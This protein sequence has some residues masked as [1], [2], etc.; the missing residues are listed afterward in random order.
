CA[1]FIVVSTAIFHTKLFCHRYLYMVDVVPVPYGLKHRIRKAEGK[2]ILYGFFAEVV[3]DPID[4]IFLEDAAQQFIQCASGFEVVAERLLNNNTRLLQFARKSLCCQILGDGRE[5]SRCH[6]QVVYYNWI[7]F[8]LRPEPINGLSLQCVRIDAGNFR[9][10][11]L[12]TLS[13]RFPLFVV[14]LAATRKFIYSLC[15]LITVLVVV[16][17]RTPKS[18]NCKTRRHPSVEIQI[19]QCRY[20]F[21]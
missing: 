3:I 7:F 16:K 14:C 21:A 18:Y 20:D 1:S 6:S 2:E 10:L 19:V 17:L 9:Y 13:K 4:L 12:Y 8:P 11:I 15:K 5:E